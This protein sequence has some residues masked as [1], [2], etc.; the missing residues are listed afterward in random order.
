MQVASFQALQRSTPCVP[1]PGE[2][3]GL[4]AVPLSP[5]HLRYCA[6][7]SKCLPE[8]T[9]SAALPAALLQVIRTWGWRLLATLKTPLLWDFSRITCVDRHR[10]AGSCRSRFSG[11]AV[12]T[13][14]ASADCRRTGGLIIGMITRTTLGHTGRLLKIG[15]LEAVCYVLLQCAVVL[16][17]LPFFGISETGYLHAMWSSAAAWSACFT[18]LVQIRS[19][20]DQSSRRWTTGLAQNRVP[21]FISRF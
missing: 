17:M 12:G 1:C 3:S 20:S 9:A 4:N 16:R 15:H 11:N 18:L 7:Q 14:T 2:T 8:V 21:C 5:P 10:L 6:G 13:G 19:D